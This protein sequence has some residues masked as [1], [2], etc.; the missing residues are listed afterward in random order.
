MTPEKMNEY[1]KVFVEQ[2][3][4]GFSQTFT[5]IIWTMNIGINATNNNWLLYK[6]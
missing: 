6:Y 5:E 1:Q 3:L 2:L 4:T